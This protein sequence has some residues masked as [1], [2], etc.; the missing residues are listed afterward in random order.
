MENFIEKYLSQYFEEVEPAAFYR[1]IFPLGELEKKEERQRGKYNAIAVELLPKVEEDKTPI[2]RYIINDDLK[3]IEELLESEN[4]IIISPVSYCGKSRESK[5]ARFIYA[6][7]FDLDGITEEQHIIDLFYQME[8][9]VLPLPTY[10]V[11]SG[12]GLHLY[13]QLEK[14]LPCFKNIVLQLANLK[15]DLTKQLWNRYTTA[16]YKTPQI[17]SLFQGFRMVG[18]ITKDGKKRTRAFLTGDKVSI[19]YLNSFATDEKNKV[20]EYKY[21]SGLTLAAAAEKFPEWYEKRIVQQQPRG[22]W[23][24]KRDLF[25]WW[26]RKMFEG[27]KEGHRYYCVMCLAIYAKKCGISREELEDYAFNIVAEFDKLT[28]RKDNAFT[29][30]DI[31]AALEMYNDNYIRF[32]IKSIS[33]LTDIPIEKNKRNGRKQKEHIKYMNTI[34]KFKVEM[35]ELKIR[36]GSGAPTKEHIVREWQQ[37]NPK[38]TQYRC[39]KETGLSINTVK[40]WWFK[41]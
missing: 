14:P 38:G 35:G 22:T 20:V 30:A 39:A 18:G 34:R 24:C 28:T 6:L 1:D 32:P 25:E 36:S 7:A 3:R 15:R 37:H 41:S 12:S 11:F 5:N 10:T 19:E 29:R 21:K 40:K 27:V 2:K 4:F 9:E 13:Y 33:T 23:T 26:K 17:E 16:L 8:N 31:L